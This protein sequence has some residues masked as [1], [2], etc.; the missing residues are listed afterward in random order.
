MKKILKVVLMAAAMLVLMSFGVRAGESENREYIITEDGG[1]YILSVYSNGSPS[2]VMRS[3]DFGDINQYISSLSSA[4]VIFGGI[5]VNENIEFLGRSHTFSGSLSMQGGAVLTVSSGN[6]IMKDFTLTLSGGSLRIKDG[7][8]TLEESSINSQGASAVILNYSAGAK[9]I[10]ESGSIYSD[11]KSASVIIDKGSAFIRGGSIKNQSGAGIETSSTLTL[12]GKVQISGKLYGAVASAPITLS[13]GGVE[14]QAD[15]DVKY[16][17][18]FTVGSIECVFYS[19]SEKSISG[20]S[21]YDIFGSEQPVT[22]FEKYSG[23]EEKSFGA[24]YLPYK[25]NYY[26]DDTLINTLELTD[27]MLADNIT[28]PEKTGYEFLGW[29]IGDNGGALYD[30]A[31]KIDKSFDLYAKYRL[32]PPSFSVSSLEFTYDGLEHSFGISSLSHP[33]SE[34]ALVSYLWYRD[35]VP[36]SDVGPILKITSVGQSGNYS[37]KVTFTYGTDT[38]SVTTPEVSVRVNKAEV[39]VPVIAE[40]SYTGEYLTP[41]VYSTPY[42]TVSEAGGTLVGIYPVKI[43]LTDPENC[44]FSTGGSIAYSDFSIVK[45]DNFWTAELSVLDIYEGMLPSPKAASRFGEVTFLYSSESGGVYTETPPDTAGRYYCIATVLE[46]E[47]YSALVSQPLEFSVF[48][49]IANGI[50]IYTM[51]NKTDYK[52]FDSFIADGLSLSVSFNSGRWEIISADKISLT[53]QTADSLRYGDNAVIASYLDV[54]IAIPVSVG[55]M[56]YDIS[57]VVFSD[58]TVVFDGEKKTIDY[59]GVLPMG[60]DGIPLTAT[61]IGGGTNAG[62]YTVVL[63][64]STA[65]KNYIAPSPIEATLTVTPYESRV[66]FSNTDFVY[67]GNLKCPEAYYTDVYGR[68]ISLSVSGARSL[69][70]EYTAVA[71]GEDGNYILIGSSTPYKI[72]K[73][74]YDFSGIFWSCDSFTYDGISKSVSISGLP[75]GVSV[76]GY[77]DNTATEAGIYTAKATVIYDED[78]Y[79]P[80]PSLIHEWVIEKA[81]YDLSVFYF[82][83]TVYIYN[84]REQFPKLIGTMPTGIDGITLAYSFNK[85][86]THV[87]EG[88]SEVKISFRTE[89]ENY[90]IPDDVSAYARIEPMGIGVIWNNFEFVYDTVRHAPTAFANECAVSVVGDATDAGSYIATAVSL[91]SDYYIVNQTAEFVINK[92]EN[93]WTV[94]VSAKDIFEGRVPEPYAEC[95]GG[96]ILYLYYSEDGSPLSEAPSSAGKYYV[97]AYTEGSKNYNSIK[98]EKR[99]FTVIEVVPVSMTVAMKRV[100][101]SAFD[102]VSPE[103]FTVA[104]HNNDGSYAE[105]DPFLITV[106]YCSAE[107]LRYNDAYIKISYLGF[108]VNAE[109]SVKK[110]D[111]DMSSVRWSDTEFI[112]DGSEKSIT[113]IGL[114]NGVSVI[115]YLGNGGT[116]AGSYTVTAVLSYD[117]VN[118]N[119]PTVSA[120]S[121]VIKKRTLELPQISPLI[122]NGREQMPSVPASDLYTA[123]Y[124]SG[125]NA[126]LYQV[127]FKVTDPHNYAFSDL[128]LEAI[129][130]YEISPRKITVQLSD[131]EKYRLSSMP[132]PHYTVIDGEIINGDDLSLAFSYGDEEVICVSENQNY[133]LTVIPGKITRHSTLSEDTVFLLFIIFLIILTVLLL[134]FLIIF[135]RRDIMHYVSV[136]KCRLSPVAK[137]AALPPEAEEISKS[138]ELNSEAIDLTMSVDAEHADSLIS[139]SL[140]KELVKREDIK[141]ETAGTKKRIINVDTLSENFSSGDS[142]DVNK[143]KEMSLVPYDTA[144]VKILARGMIDKP[145]KVYANDF[146]LSAVKMIALTGGEAIRVITVRK[147]KDRD[148]GKGE[149]FPENS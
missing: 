50:S 59:P 104:L 126:G 124:G 10:M 90:N 135:R 5:A 68:K 139:D 147:K 58:S 146:S 11:S 93:F 138:E 98:S 78:N 45:A 120:G 110:A 14:F 36:V 91:N 53:Y 61:V 83:D 117:A 111:Y 119:P 149:K 24:V 115:E 71:S 95:L 55:K 1:E 101:F 35:G 34:N 134:I 21:L 132:K 123:E 17:K 66:V 99:E 136:I 33:L 26:S 102:K 56:E 116:V 144:Y 67:D 39:E 106:S 40:K 108:T 81:D 60:L 8:V 85:G 43:T 103:D 140:A 75:K 7:T 54:S 32:L 9:F 107:S 12:S 84:G 113:L 131:I 48:S 15:L 109:V 127:I 141:I 65:S 6:L 31:Q 69:A 86:V 30:F 16:Q 46:T 63:S 130:Y 73:A 28:A 27:G 129:S 87:S 92:A 38:V 18:S 20:I 118:C 89:S 74:D 29:G 97:E 25:V 42:Y 88:R 125:V 137:T 19:A 122:Y 105:I 143:L 142:V 57:G 23:I 64:F 37:A 82:E 94:P 79:N 62:V 121:F 100:D 47:N 114:P 3:L 44:E 96:E 133:S 145:L 49:E 80:P 128:S 52:A 41:D 77:A 148:D 22:Y 70:G 72:A 13:D 112:Y 2:P 51:P 76:V 4:D